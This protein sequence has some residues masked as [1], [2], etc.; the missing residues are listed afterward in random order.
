VKEGVNE[1]PPKKRKSPA[2]TGQKKSKEFLKRETQR[3]FTFNG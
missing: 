2:F 3:E 1:S